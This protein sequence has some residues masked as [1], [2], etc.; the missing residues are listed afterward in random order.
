MRRAA[1]PAAHPRLA[2][3]WL[4]A[5]DLGCR[6]A[7]GSLTILGRA[8]D[9][10]VIGGVNVLP[11]QVEARLA[12]VP[13]IGQAA[14]AGVP[15]PVWG[16]TLAVCYTGAIAPEALESWC[17]AHLPGAE[18]PRIFL[19]RRSLPQLASGKVDAAAIRRLAAADGTTR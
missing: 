7:D 8:D 18:R 13:D 19:R 10:L 15:H 3:G 14:V 1:A 9:R 17:R 2:D 5:A 12:A 11:S 16:Q 6:G 4:E